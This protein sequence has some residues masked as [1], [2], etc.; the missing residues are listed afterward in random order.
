MVNASTALPKADRSKI[1]D[2][3]EGSGGMLLTLDAKGIARLWSLT[4]F[5]QDMNVRII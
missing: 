5:P 3:K 1:I 2:I 4:A